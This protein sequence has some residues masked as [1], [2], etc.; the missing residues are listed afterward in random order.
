VSG[1]RTIAFSRRHAA[2]RLSWLA[3]SLVVLT[4]CDPRAVRENADQAELTL[5]VGSAGDAEMDVLLGGIEDNGE[6]LNVAEMVGRLVFPDARA[7]RVDIDGN[8]G[9]WD[10]AVVHAEGVYVPGPAPV[11]ELDSRGAVSILRNTGFT[12]VRVTV[13]VPSV[14]RDVVFDPQGDRISDNTWEWDVGTVDDAPRVSIT[15]RPEEWRGWLTLLLYALVLGGG[16][17]G[18]LVWIRARSRRWA[19]PA[20]I[21]AGI[22]GFGAFAFTAVADSFHSVDNLGV[23]GVLGPLPLAVVGVVLGIGAFI[24]V[25]ISVG[26]AVVGVVGPPSRRGPP[27]R[28]DLT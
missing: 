26:V 15:M 11:L 20:M 19:R 6:L 1:T 18:A 21:A 7:V 24:A 12:D 28:P 27:P 23:S 25:F 2:R 14:P 5:E 22:V 8:D 16:A 17:I 9:G 10:F 4:A 3:L 13:R